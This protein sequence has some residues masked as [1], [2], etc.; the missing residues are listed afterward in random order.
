MRK[1]LFYLCYV[2]AVLAAGILYYF[3][4]RTGISNQTGF[5]VGESSLLTLFY[6][7]GIFLLVGLYIWAARSAAK[8]EGASAEGNSFLWGASSALCG[9]LL[10]MGGLYGG[11]QTASPLFS[12]EA[13]QIPKLFLPGLDCFLSLAAALSFMMLGVRLLR[14]NLHIYRYSRSLLWISLW[15]AFRLVTRFGQLPMAFRMPQRL[16]EILMMTAQCLFLLAGS[17]LICNVIGKKSYRWALFS[18]HAATALGLI[19]CVCPLVAGNLALSDLSQM[20]NYWMEWGLVLFIG[21]FCF[22]ITPADQKTKPAV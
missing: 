19:W 1:K 2:P 21:L 11:W 5:Y 4:Y 14:Q 16:L 8:S 22:F 17:H 3:L 20:L 9:I 6:V 18:G 12:R 10:L 7:L 15:S 13:V